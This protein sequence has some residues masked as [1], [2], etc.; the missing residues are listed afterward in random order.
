MALPIGAVAALS[1]KERF[2]G[3]GFVR[4][5]PFYMKIVAKAPCRVD[6][7]GGTLDIWPLYL[8]HPGAVTVNFAVQVYATCT[9][10]ERNDGRVRLRSTDLAVDE[11]LSD[12]HAAK[13]PLP[14]HLVRFFATIKQPSSPLSRRICRDGR[15]SNGGTA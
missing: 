9:V 1:P 8:F 12:V 3:V 7:A 14:A 6:L 15:P 2:L 10:R 4:E 5:V 13:L 11:F